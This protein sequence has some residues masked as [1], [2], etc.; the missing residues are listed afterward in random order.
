MILVK[1]KKDSWIVYKEEGADI[2]LLKIYTNEE[3]QTLGWFTTF[4]KAEF[5]AN[6]FMLG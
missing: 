3:W 1:E 2:F 6:G 5:I 4:E